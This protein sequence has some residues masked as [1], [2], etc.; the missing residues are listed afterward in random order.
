M[1]EI[2]LKMSNITKEFF[3]V[4]ALEDVNFEVRRGEIHAIC[5][6]NGAGK[7]TLMNILSGTL[8]HGSYSGQILLDGEECRFNNI[9]ESE[10]KGIVIVHQELA[11]NPHLSIDENIFIGNERTKRFGVIDW[12]NT[13]LQAESILKTVGFEGENLSLP[14]NRLGVGKKQLVEIAKSL[15]KNARIL[16]L[17]EPTA[18][19][20]DQESD[21][22]LSLLVDLK[23]KGMTII[24]ISHK[25]HELERVSDAITILRDGKTIITFEKQ[26]TPF[27]EG[28]IIKSMVGR[29]L[30][31]RFPPR[32]NI[33]IG[34]KVFEVESW[35]VNHPD[36]DQKVMVRNVNFHARKGEIV[37]FAGLM[38]A[39]RTELA[40]S[41]FGHSY[42]KDI[43]GKIKINGQEV[44]ISNIDD[45]LNHGVAYLTEDRKH[46]GLILI[47]DVKWNMSLPILKSLSR[48]GAINA[49]EEVNVTGDFCKRLNVRINSLDQE[50]S[51]LSGGNQQKVVLA[52]WILTQPDVLILDEPT[53]GIDVGAKY[54]FY[55]IIYELVHQGKSI[56]LISSDMTEL[57][58]LSDRIYVINEGEIINEMNRSEFS[59]EK[60]MESIINHSR[61]ENN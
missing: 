37:G 1:S 7:S 61:R 54:E 21:R 24:L 3:G 48:H 53:R 15:A 38:G 56:I 13:R 26:T 52:K 49:I 32:D 6:E 29:P 18:A 57:L 51:S 59:Q 55:Q 46:Y 50:V 9:K 33:E 10:K 14:V 12:V 60:I 20:N 11:L 30:T 42:G 39:G 28:L 23:R 35:S 27:D 58:G 34:E 16:I 19:L 25:I 40:M 8:P 45:A 5:G 31:N 22:L 44:E 43:S 17:D 36:Y 2:I 47:K 41:I 4:K